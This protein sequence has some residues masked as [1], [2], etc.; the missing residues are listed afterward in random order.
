[1]VLDLRPLDEGG[2]RSGG[3][4]GRGVALEGDVKHHADER[5]ALVGAGNKGLP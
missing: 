1:M 4:G 3:T 5:E 2:A